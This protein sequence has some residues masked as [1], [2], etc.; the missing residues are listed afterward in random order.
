MQ[1]EKII[2]KGKKLFTPS[3]ES[4]VGK[5]QNKMSNPEVMGEG[6]IKKLSNVNSH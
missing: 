2:R 4:V 3:N 5:K 6:D 1:K